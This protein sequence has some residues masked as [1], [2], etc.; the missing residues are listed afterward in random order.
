M[1]SAAKRWPPIRQA[2]GPVRPPIAARALTVSRDPAS[3]SKLPSSAFSGAAVTMLITPPIAWLPHRIDCGPRNRSEEHTSELQ[4]L[5]R[6]S[7]AVFCLKK[8]TQQ[9]QEQLDRSQLLKEK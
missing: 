8:K 3:R 9:Q 6:I 1:P 4:S 2:S 5:M 7:Y